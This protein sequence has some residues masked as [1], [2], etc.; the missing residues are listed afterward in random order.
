[1][2]GNIVPSFAAADNRIKA[3]FLEHDATVLGIKTFAREV[4]PR[5]KETFSDAAIS[6]LRQEKLAV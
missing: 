3:R 5:L 4:Y 1:M 2:T 6:G